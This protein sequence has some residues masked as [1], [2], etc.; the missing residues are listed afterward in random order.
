MTCDVFLCSVFLCSVLLYS[1]PPSSLTSLFPQLRYSAHFT[2]DP[3]RN[4]VITYFPADDNI[5]VMEV[6]GGAGNGAKFLS[7]A[8]VRKGTGRE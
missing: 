7:K 8:R 5:S 4:V 2:D 3:S 1:S 6:G